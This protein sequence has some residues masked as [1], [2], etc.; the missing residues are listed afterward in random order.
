MN[1]GYADRLGSG[2]RNLYYY[3]KLYSGKEPKLTE[4]DIF[5]TIVTLPKMTNAPQVTPQDSKLDIVLEAGKIRMTI[6]D[7]PNSCHQKY[8]KA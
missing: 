2:M 1:I 3:S 8:V 6:P 4:G 7:K 5:T